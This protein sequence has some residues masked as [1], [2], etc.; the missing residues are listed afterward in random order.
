MSNSNIEKIYIGK[1]CGSFILVCKMVT[2]GRMEIPLFWLSYYYDSVILVIHIHK[3]L[4]KRHGLAWSI[5]G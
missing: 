3:L 1:V 5:W 2:L 4:A